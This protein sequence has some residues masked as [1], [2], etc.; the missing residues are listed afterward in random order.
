M[1]LPP[2][3]VR[4]PARNVRVCEACFLSQE[5][6]SFPRAGSVN[7]MGSFGSNSSL[8]ALPAEMHS[9]SVLTRKGALKSSMSSPAILQL[10]LSVKGENGVMAHSDSID[11]EDDSSAHQSPRANDAPAVRGQ[12]ARAPGADAQAPGSPNS[13]SKS[14][15]STTTT[16]P[17]RVPRGSAEANQVEA[18]EDAGAAKHL[19]E[20]LAPADAR[21]SEW[22]ANIQK[23]F[24]ADP[25]YHV[26]SLSH[27]F[28]FQPSLGHVIF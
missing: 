10:L 15:K 19:L 21:R 3:G 24:G 9:P 13:D 11:K 23:K 14:S 5:T 22:I 26:R 1:M 27:C 17:V 2:P 25:H 20:V 28:S 8:D 16:S 4:G 7:S 6:F 18:A 12:F